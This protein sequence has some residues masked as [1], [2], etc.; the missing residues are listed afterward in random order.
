MDTDAPVTDHRRDAC[1]M[2][3]HYGVPGMMMRRKV[4]GEG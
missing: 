2:I 3:I 4:E 1:Q